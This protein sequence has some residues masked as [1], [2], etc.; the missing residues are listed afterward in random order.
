MPITFFYLSGSPFAWK[1]WLALECKQLPYDLRVLSAD[2]GDLRTAKFLALNPRGKV[3]VIVDDGFVLTESSAIVEYLEERNP[4]A[5]RPLW[6][7]DLGTRAAARRIAV[8]GDG[9]IYPNVRMLVV[10]LLMRKS[11][12]PDA[13]IVDAAKNALARE[14]NALSDRIAGPFFMGPEPSVADFA[15]YPFLAVYNRVRQS[16]PN[17][18]IGAV[19]SRVDAWMR[20]VEALPYFAK[21]IPPHWRAAP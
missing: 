4:V 14:L 5:G 12:S 9:F 16:R 6:P 8:E 2:A 11:G 1:V 17:E 18:A 19:P 3:P 10:E 7:A 20:E 21:T 13:A 15:I